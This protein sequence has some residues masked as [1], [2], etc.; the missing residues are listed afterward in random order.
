MRIGLLTAG[1]YPYRRDALSTWCRLLVEGLD[2][3]TFHLRTLT[4]RVPDGPP[5]LR[6]PAHVASAAAVPVEAI[7]PTSADRTGDMTVAAA[8]LCRGLLGGDDRGLAMVKDALVRLAEHGDGDPLRGV[9]LADLLHDAW[10]AGRAALPTGELPPPLSS[11]DAVQAAGLLRH[12][13]RATVAAVP[14]VDVLHAVG[15]TA[16]VLAALAE[17]WRS[18]TPL[19]VT[20]ARRPAGS[21]PGED[22]FSP[23]VRA[24]LRDFRQAVTRLAYGSAALVAPMSTYHRGRA[25][26]YG[27]DPSKLVTVPAAADPRR[28]LPGPDL[29]DRPSLVWTGSRPGPELRTVLEAYGQVLAGRPGTTLHLYAPAPQRTRLRALTE[30]AGVTTGVRLDEAP[31]DHRFA[32]AR[33]QVTVYAPGPEDPPHRL[34]QAMF[35]A[36]PI[37]GVDVGPVAETLGDTGVVVPPNDPAAL[38]AACSALLRDADLR[39]RLGAAARRRAL[40]HYTPAHLA[41]AYAALYEDVAGDRRNEFDLAIPA[42]RAAVPA[43]ARWFTPEPWFTPEDA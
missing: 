32:Y 21:R 25:L 28:L 42:P 35:T 41:R 12:A 14:D 20:E 6:L 34:V 11:A 22:R 37:V 26:R 4:D 10:R 27:A 24:T 17:H 31:A 18:G 9:P 36:C 16:A 8:L 7:R 1:G 33:A 43:T 39:A 23:G 5:A 19:L 40:A 29:V 3:H 38:A 2:Q 30:R 15:G 13:C